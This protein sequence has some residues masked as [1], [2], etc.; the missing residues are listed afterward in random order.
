MNFNKNQVKPP[1]YVPENE[2]DGEEQRI[3]LPNVEEVRSDCGD[4]VRQDLDVEESEEI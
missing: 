3:S 1:V 4:F 2:E